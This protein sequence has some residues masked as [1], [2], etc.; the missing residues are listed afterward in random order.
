MKKIF[1]QKFIAPILVA[2][3]FMLST[4]IFASSVTKLI[5]VQTAPNTIYVDNSKIATESFTYNGTTYVPLRTITESMGANVQFDA[6]AK[7][8]NITS[9]GTGVVPNTSIPTQNNN[10]NTTTTATNVVNC[11]G[12]TLTFGSNL[13]YATLENQF[14]ERNGQTVILIPV[15]ITNNNADTDNFN[16]FNMDTF[17]PNGNELDDVSAYFDQAYSFE[18]LRSGATLDTYFTALY[19]GNGTYVI[20]FDDYTTKSEYKFNVTR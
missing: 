4:S 19:D 20:E 13:E 15:T 18:K 9:A 14:S 12:F 8:I 2:S 17:S 16:T 11:D 7:R 1:K 5:E 3:C 10:S 6:N